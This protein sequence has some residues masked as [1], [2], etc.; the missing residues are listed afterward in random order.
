MTV[1]GSGLHVNKSIVTVCMH[2]QLVLPWCLHAFVSNKKVADF[3]ASVLRSAG[4]QFRLINLFSSYFGK[5]SISLIRHSGSI[6]HCYCSSPQGKDAG[7][8]SGNW[9]RGLRA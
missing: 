3:P 8:I 5:H 1:G 7:G 2:G 6:H 4:A 9:V